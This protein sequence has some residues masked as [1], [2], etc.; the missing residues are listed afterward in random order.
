MDLE[1]ILN[2]TFND[3]YTRLA[4]KPI[5]TSETKNVDNIFANIDNINECMIC[6][7]DDRICIK[8]FQCTAYYC[9][10]CLI[11]ISSDFNKCSSCSIKIKENYNKFKDYNQELQEQLQILQ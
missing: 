9:K 5:S 10:E 7:N 1:S 8:C 4:N 6:C 11:K 2:Q 3:E